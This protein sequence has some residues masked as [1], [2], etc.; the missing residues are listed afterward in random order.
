MTPIPAISLCLTTFNRPTETI[1]AFRNVLDDF[2]IGEIV[3]VDDWSTAANY[4][5][6]IENVLKLNSPKIKLFRNPK[7]LGVYENKKISVERATNDYCIVFDSDNKLNTDYIDKV[8][9]FSNDPNLIVAP[10]HAMPDFDYKSFARLI[11]SR[12]NVKQYLNRP[13]FD[14]LLNTMN[15]FV[16]RNEYLKVWE[17]NDKVNISDS[18]YMNYL[19]LR[20]GKKIYICPGLNYRHVVHQGSNYITN[21]NKAG[22]LMPQDVKKLIEKLYETF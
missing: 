19:W 11:I 5:L 2:R 8:F 12:H 18:I 3:I 20:A 10:D 9:A 17:P 14:A 16:N 15:Y 22:Q 13:M 4:S 1:E 7:N 6:L 21:E